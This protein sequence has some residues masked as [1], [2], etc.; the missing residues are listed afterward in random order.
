MKDKQEGPGGKGKQA[1]VSPTIDGFLERYGSSFAV[2]IY[3]AHRRHTIHASSR[4]FTVCGTPRRTRLSSELMT[5]CLSVESH[6]NKS[7]EDECKGQ[8]FTFLA[9]LEAG[10]L[11][12]LRDNVEDDLLHG[13]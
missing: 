4:D 6:L 3:D 13:T 5:Y 2:Y 8:G 11:E 7:S 1:R 10:G 9:V 12:N